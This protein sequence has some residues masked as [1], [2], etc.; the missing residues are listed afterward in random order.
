ME[1]VS[2]DGDGEQHLAYELV[3][4]CQRKI[5]IDSMEL[6]SPSPMTKILEMLSDPVEIAD[7]V[8]HNFVQDPDLRQELL[9][10]VYV[11][12]RLDFLIELLKAS[13]KGT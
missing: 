3:A 8:G 7:M 13:V 6:A 1:C 12:D 2:I 4:L 9:E 11:I 10:L 5:E